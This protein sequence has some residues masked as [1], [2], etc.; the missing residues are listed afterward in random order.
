[1]ARPHKGSL[2]DAIRRCGRRPQSDCHQQPEGGAFPTGKG[3]AKASLS[4]TLQWKGHVLLRPCLTASEGN[5]WEFKR[6][7][8][9][10]QSHFE[11]NG[12]LGP[13]VHCIPLAWLPSSPS[14]EGSV[15]WTGWCAGRRSLLLHTDSAAVSIAELCAMCTWATRWEVGHTERAGDRASP[16]RVS[17][18]LLGDKNP[19]AA[20][21][22]RIHNTDRHPRSLK[23]KNKTHSSSR[24][25]E[26]KRQPVNGISG[27]RGERFYWAWG[28]APPTRSLTAA[29][30]D[31]HRCSIRSQVKK[32]DG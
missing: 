28:K 9:G 24:N 29:W 20:V 11:T 32:P 21:G 3:F 8:S 22:Q 10:I 7:L 12:S 4:W 5:T 30:R 15:P 26:G 23:T 14:A 31:G 2:E 27:S 19:H 17:R 6:L 13:R 16:D 25:R 1:M 18:R